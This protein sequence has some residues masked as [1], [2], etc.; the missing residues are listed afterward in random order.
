MNEADNNQWMTQ[1]TNKQVLDKIKDYMEKDYVLGIMLWGSRATGFGESDTDWDA[2]V[3]VTDEYYNTLKVKET[4]YV[5][6]NLDI[7]PKKVLID[8][9]LWSEECAHQILTSPKDIDHWAWVEGKIIYDPYG[10]VIK[11]KEA[12]SHYPENE[13]EQRLKTKFI[14]LL[15]SRYYAMVT[16]K[17]GYTPDSMLNLYRAIITAIHLWFTLQKSW[18][19]SLKWWTEHAKRMGMKEDIYALFSNL[20]E[21]PSIQQLIKVETVLKDEIKN[22]G[23]VFPDDILQVLLEGV[24]VTGRAY[25]LKHSYL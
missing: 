12:I 25:M 17:R 9:S 14:D 10:K 23:Y 7:E 3:L 16:E 19:P 13:H 6:Y 24:H 4:A 18:T 8:F 21:N 15:V 1:I 20:L 11:W 5:L 2:L 22:Q